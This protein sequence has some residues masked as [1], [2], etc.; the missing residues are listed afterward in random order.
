MIMDGVEPAINQIFKVMMNIGRETN[1]NEIHQKGIHLRYPPSRVQYF[2]NI[3]SKRGIVLFDQAT[4][5]YS[6]IKKAAKE[7]LKNDN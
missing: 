6:I 7:I 5:K 1:A 4:M 3:M 2:L